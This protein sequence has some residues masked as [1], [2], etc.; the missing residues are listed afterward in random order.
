[1]LSKGIDMNNQS[2]FFFLRSL[3]AALLVWVGVTAVQAQEAV[4][5]KNIAERLPDFPK[6]DEV[7]KTAVPGIYELRAGTDVFYS[8]EQGQY[9]IQGQ[10]MD[11]RTRVNMTQA[12]IDKLTAINFASLP[13][14]DA[15]VSKQG[16]GARKL[17]VFSD[18][19]CGY[20]KKI[21]RDLVQLKD[22]TIYTFLYPILNEDSAE[23]SQNIWCAKD[24]LKTWR[25]WML[26]TVEPLKAMGQCDLSVLQRNVAM[27]HKYRI[28][29]TPALVFENG[30][31]VPGA[32]SLGAIEQQLAQLSKK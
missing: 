11:T 4:I 5:R 24:Q 15:V 18:P 31:R 6:I 9:L 23:K 29:G 7:S 27:G 22:V 1:V 10:I 21:E 8:D 14:K 3:S 17:V 32:M 26:D 16:T 19:N 28:N 20:C 2:T 12:R 25:S 13:L 30:R